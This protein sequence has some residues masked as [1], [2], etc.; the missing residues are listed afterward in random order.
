M[1]GVAQVLQVLQVLMVEACLPQTLEAQGYG[2]QA[3]AFRTLGGQKGA[4]RD[5]AQWVC[6]ARTWVAQVLVES[7]SRFPILG[8]Q[9]ARVC[10]VSR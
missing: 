3:S 9:E 1:V 8:A 4:E 7:D 6:G 2:V 5:S 10:A